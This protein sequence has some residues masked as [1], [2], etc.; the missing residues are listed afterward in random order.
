MAA[1]VGVWLSCYVVVFP[2]FVLH[3]LWSYREGKKR[4]EEEEA[5]NE[6]RELVDLRFLLSDYKS[7]TPV[8]LWECIEVSGLQV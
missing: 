4:K 7:I 5:G 3:K 6:N 8:I 1:Y 2:L